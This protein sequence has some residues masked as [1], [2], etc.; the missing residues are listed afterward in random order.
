M[1]PPRPSARRALLVASCVAALLCGCARHAAHEATHGLW[2]LGTDLPAFDPD[3]PPDAVRASI[4]RLLTRGLVEED[5]AGRPV[6]GIAQSIDASAD[7][8]TWTFHLPAGLRYSDG[9]PCASGDFKDALVQGLG[10]PDHA[11]RSW[12][13][14]AVRGVK[15]VRVGRPRPNLGVSTPDDRTLVLELATPDPLLL[16]KLARPGV[17]RAWRSREAGTWRGAVGLGP[18]TLVRQDSTRALELVGPA[19]PGPDTLTLR[20]LTIPAR[21][22]SML[23]E[24]RPDLVWPLPAGLPRDVPSNY[25]VTSREA[26]PARWMVLVMRADVPPTTRLPARQALAHGVNGPDVL[27]ALDLRV[28]PITGFVPG[29][30]TM[31]FPRLDPQEIEMWRERGKLGRSFHVMLLYD[32]RGAP[33]DVARLLQGEWSRHDVYAELASRAGSKLASD[34]LT[35]QAQVALAVH[36]D[37]IATPGGA[38]ASWVMPLRGPAVGDIRT[39]WR[40]REFDGWIEPGRSSRPDPESVQRRLEQERIVLPLAR[41]P[42]TW[43]ERSAPGGA[44][45]F[46]PRTGP[47][48]PIPPP[49]AP[50][51]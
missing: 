24:G 2:V 49:A 18:Y 21:V 16:A 5:S 29:A 34:L 36:Q 39:G 7:S 51:R 23:R 22:R 30:G 14:A 19:T 4:E 32:G 17:G 47:S 12:E 43:I 8:L 28:E 6:P 3:G 9:S 27:R 25:R 20:F 48:C 1:E 50:R 33:A 42:W 44:A 37:L 10:R 13:L 11:T 35:G 45:R 41:M 46:D 38:I 31:D 26:S 15:D 40:T